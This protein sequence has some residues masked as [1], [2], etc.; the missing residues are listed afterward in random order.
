[1]WMFAQQQET[2]DRWKNVSTYHLAGLLVRWNVDFAR[3]RHQICWRW[4]LSLQS[5]PRNPHVQNPQ[6]CH[7]CWHCR[8]RLLPCAAADF[9]S[10]RTT[11]RT[12]ANCRLSRR[13]TISCCLNLRRMWNWLHPTLTVSARQLHRL[14]QNCECVSTILLFI[15][16]IFL[17]HRWWRHCI[18]AETLVSANSKIF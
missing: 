10:L 1:M 5:V 7:R 8:R 2:L 12:T 18:M 3:H 4:I 16:L 9:S 11:R 13:G 17:W 15:L 6:V 14:I